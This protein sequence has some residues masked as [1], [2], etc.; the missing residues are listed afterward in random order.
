MTDVKPWTTRK[1]LAPL[2][3][4][5]LLFLAA[6]SPTVAGNGEP[7]APDTIAPD[8]TSSSDAVKDSAQPN[9][10]TDPPRSNDVADAPQSNDVA[11]APRNERVDP[12]NYEDLEIVTLLP[13]DAIPAID[14]PRFLDVEEADEFYDPNELIMGVEF[15]GE[16]RAYSVPFLSR[17][18]IVN[19][20][21]GGVK[22]AVT[23]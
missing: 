23:W 14:A 11:D 15:N 19:D 13:R 18:E 2:T 20:T 8:P 21:V 22:I 12:S 6:C 1:G 16:A 7:T 3:F 4:L 10:V 5:C 9:D 17:H